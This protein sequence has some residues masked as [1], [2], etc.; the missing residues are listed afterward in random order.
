MSNSVFLPFL[1]NARDKEASCFQGKGPRYFNEQQKKSLNLF[2]HMAKYLAETTDYDI[3][4]HKE[5][6]LTPPPKPEYFH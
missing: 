6:I 5:I 3:I 1:F 2:K 4:K